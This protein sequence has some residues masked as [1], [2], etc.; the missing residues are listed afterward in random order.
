MPTPLYQSVLASDETT[1]PNAMG[2]VMAPVPMQP[3]MMQG[4]GVIIS[5]TP[6]QAINPQL[7]LG[8]LH[9]G[10]HH[11][12]NGGPVMY[13]PSIN[14]AAI[15]TSY[16]TEGVDPSHMQIQS[17]TTPT[18]QQQQ[19]YITPPMDGMPRFDGQ[20]RSSYADT[21]MTM[22]DGT[23][24][25]NTALSQSAAPTPTSVATVSHSGGST[26]RSRPAT[27][28]GHPGSLDFTTLR[29]KDEDSN[30]TSPY[31]SS[32]LS[33]S[34]FPFSNSM[35][36]QTSGSRS[37]ATSFSRNTSASRSRA[38]SVN[39]LSF[40]A[41]HGPDAQE[42]QTMLGS[43][44]TLPSP[45]NEDDD[46]EEH[47]NHADS[48]ESRSKKDNIAPELMNKYNHIF[49]Q[50]LPRVCSDVDVTDRKGEKIH[51]PLM[52]KK[53]AK[54]D[55]ERA[56]R[57]F[58]FR[59]QPFTNSFQDACRDLG[60][61]EAETAPKLIKQFLWNQPL[62][63]RFNDEGKKTKSRGN[64]VWSIEARIIAPGHYEFRPPP[65][66][67]VPLPAT[68][69]PKI[70]WHWCPKVLDSSC[71]GP[72]MSASFSC[73]NLPDWLEFRDDILEGTPPIDATS[74]MLDIVAE[75]AGHKL[76]QTFTVA[77]VAEDGV[78]PVSNYRTLPSPTQDEQMASAHTSHSHTPT[79]T[80]G[81][82]HVGD[83]SGSSLSSGLT[84]STNSLMTPPSVATLQQGN[85]GLLP[86]PLPALSRDKA[87]T[88]SNGAGLTSKMMP[89]GPAFAIPNLS[90]SPNSPQ[91]PIYNGMT[92]Q[93]RQPV[94]M[95]LPT[96]PTDATTL[97][98]AS[99]I[100]QK[101]V[102]ATT[103]HHENMAALNP[104]LPPPVQSHVTQAVDHAIR[105]ELAALGAHPTMPTAVEVFNATLQVSARSQQWQ[106][107]QLSEAVTAVTQSITH[108]PQLSSQVASQLANFSFTPS[109]TPGTRSPETSFIGY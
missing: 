1:V 71:Q 19:A 96:Q 36:S 58:K 35:T 87:A 62:I 33:M 97:A 61:N 84:R 49:L 34:S 77:V 15:Q 7:S 56:F 51:Q 65:P 29:P 78:R 50:W 54:L 93:I 92:G 12:S 23:T 44:N 106:S 20:G 74:I 70:Y 43:L 102:E 98:S 101:L 100:K 72:P 89:A 2:A 60:L 14:P 21:D 27:R 53:M 63:S 11:L 10:N 6:V 57:P 42:L 85:N 26:T 47:F 38:P 107:E 55:E 32:H 75:Y 48:A 39:S 99:H 109:N 16:Q 82:D 37:R 69:A 45:I 13:A 9:A 95:Y 30:L 41:S 4:N 80:G 40:N 22:A 28:A 68:A 8:G 79:T 91:Q 52:A 25:S 103:I 76:V 67:I 5:P 46:D 66:K 18:P 90:G 64:H 104:V 81:G 94:P 59:I 83:F 24:V 86:S 105:D 3:Q 88:L 73:P 108:P 31:A 17:S